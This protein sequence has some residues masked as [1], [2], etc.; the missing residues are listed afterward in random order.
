[1]STFNVPGLQY[2]V[3]DVKRDILLVSSGTNSAGSLHE[4]VIHQ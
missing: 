1:M 4:G 2:I 3:D